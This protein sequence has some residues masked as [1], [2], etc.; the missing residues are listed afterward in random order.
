MVYQTR[1]LALLTAA[2][3]SIGIVGAATMTLHPTGQGF[4]NS[5]LNV[6]CPAKTGEWQCVDEITT[7]TTDYLKANGNSMETFTF[8]DL[9]ATSLHIKSVTFYYHAQTS[10]RACIDPMIRTS[11]RVNYFGSSQ[12]GVS[13]WKTISQSFP[14]NPTTNSA[15]TAAELNKLE[16]GMRGT[17]GAQVAQMYVVVEILDSNT[18]N[19]TR[20]TQI[21]MAGVTA[22]TS[23]S[24]TSSSTEKIA[25]TKSTTISSG[26]TANSIAVPAK[27]ATVKSQVKTNVISKVAKNTTNT[28][29]ITDAKVH[30]VAKTATANMGTVRTSNTKATTKSTAKSKV[31]ASPTKFHTGSSSAKAD[32]II[33]NI[34]FEEKVIISQGN[35][36]NESRRVDALMHISVKNI[37]TAAAPVNYFGVIKNG[38]N[39]G[40]NTLPTLAVGE[41]KVVTW[42]I[43]SCTPGAYSA[44][45]DRYSQVT[46]LS[47][48]NNK[49]T[50]V[51]IDCQI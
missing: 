9:S 47:E 4:Y 46:E 17:H 7:S 2:I 48:T 35:T 20:A 11:N 40:S 19:T 13:A 49:G 38:A 45:A 37:G 5:W 1:V 27:T 51:N 50:T 33:T 41:T 31:E 16:A 26:T 23:T 3:L 44:T 42:N 15:W 28:T 21:T 34:Q 25:T 6:G 18:S 12:C 8:S 36:S 22:T 30:T 29:K 10:G 32:L 39:I 24:G 14:V 43:Y